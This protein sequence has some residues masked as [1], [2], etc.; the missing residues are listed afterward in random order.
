MVLQPVQLPERWEINIDGGEVQSVPGCKFQSRQMLVPVH[1][2]VSAKVWTEMK[3]T[4]ETSVKEEQTKK[5]KHLAEK[6]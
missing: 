1:C 5:N 2:K 3:V 4:M 6:L